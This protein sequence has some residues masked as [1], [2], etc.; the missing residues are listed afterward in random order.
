MY[1]ISL[2]INDVGNSAEQPFAVDTGAGCSQVL[3]SN[4]SNSREAG[5]VEPPVLQ[6]AFFLEDGL[7]Q[8]CM[9]LKK[10]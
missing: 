1:A 8:V 2:L 6:R 10:E 3:A 7:S 4:T 5:L 9:H